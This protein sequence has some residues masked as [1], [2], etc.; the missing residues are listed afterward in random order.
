MSE[1]SIGELKYGPMT[2]SIVDE[3]NNISINIAEYV[4]RLE[5][6]LPELFEVTRNTSD[7]ILECAKLYNPFPNELCT[8][9]KRMN[10]LLA[11][12]NGEISDE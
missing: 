10:K 3:N 6:A 11:Q 9:A 7:Y 4:A 5:A 8:Y 2:Q 1:F 12:I